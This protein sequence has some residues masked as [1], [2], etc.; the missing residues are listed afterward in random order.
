M[1]FDMVWRYGARL[2]GE[3]GYYE[4]ISD[5]EDAAEN[6]NDLLCGSIF[7][8]WYLESGAVYLAAQELLAQDVGLPVEMT[9]Q[10]WRALLPMV[11]KLARSEFNI[12]ARQC[13]SE[14]L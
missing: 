10:S 7:D 11:I 13:Y 3:V 2:N 8:S 1:L 9:D 4:K 5:I 6:E 14:R 12:D